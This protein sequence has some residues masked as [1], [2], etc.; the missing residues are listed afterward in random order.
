MLP[1]LK[2]LVCSQSGNHSA[3]L[4]TGLAVGACRTTPLAHLL[5]YLFLLL[6]H[7]QND[8]S[9]LRANVISLLVLGGRVVDGEEDIQQIFEGDYGWVICDGNHLCVTGFLATH[10]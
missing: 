4:A 2:N 1:A 6:V 9:V 7:V 10:L 3:A 8:A 5:C